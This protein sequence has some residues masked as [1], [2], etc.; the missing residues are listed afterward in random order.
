MTD[1]LTIAALIGTPVG[2]ILIGAILYKVYFRILSTEKF[3]RRA[4][5]NS[6]VILRSM[7]RSN[8][9]SPE[10]LKDLQLEE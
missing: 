9:I 4:N 8:L 1:P 5:H 10:D 2:Y 3:A 6:T 7:I